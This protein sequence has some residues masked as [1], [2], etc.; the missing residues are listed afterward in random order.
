[1]ALSSEYTIRFPSALVADLK[2]GDL[3]QVAGAAYRVRDVCIL[4]DG[5]ERR[6]MLNRLF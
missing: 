6:A 2:I 5:T 3:V 1:M 4:G